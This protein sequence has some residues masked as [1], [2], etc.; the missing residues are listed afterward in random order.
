MGNR[1]RI[2][3]LFWI[4]IIRQIQEFS[5]DM[6]C[7]KHSECHFTCHWFQLSQIF[8]TFFPFCSRLA[9]SCFSIKT[10]LNNLYKHLFKKYIECQ[11]RNCGTEEIGSG[12]ELCADSAGHV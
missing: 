9:A 8:V 7:W 5:F 3:D 12:R 11:E 4:W 10:G 6:V 1:P 2:L